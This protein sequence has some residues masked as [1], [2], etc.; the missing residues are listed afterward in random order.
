MRSVNARGDD[1]RAAPSSSSATAA[2]ATTTGGGGRFFR[3]HG[4][5]V[6]SVGLGVYFV[7]EEEVMVHAMSRQDGV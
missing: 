1:S 6:R 7:V 4:G 5:G 3:R 2:T